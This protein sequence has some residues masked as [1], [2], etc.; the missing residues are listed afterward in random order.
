MGYCS[1]EDVLKFIGPNP[2]QF[3]VDTPGEFEGLIKSWIDIAADLIDAD[4]NRTFTDDESLAKYGNLL[5]ML[6]LQII[7]NIYEF[8][9]RTRT[10]V[11]LD[12]S[13]FPP[14]T[15]KRDILTL[16]ILANLNK[17]PREKG[18]GID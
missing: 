6:S 9:I 8:C 18:W 3:G 1:I 15:L 7:A 12:L 10:G 2:Q 13:E 5:K 16:E 14:V 11:V 17:L 4:R